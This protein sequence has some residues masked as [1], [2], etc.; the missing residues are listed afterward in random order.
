MEQADVCVAAHRVG[1]RKSCLHEKVRT[2]AKHFN[3][4]PFELAAHRLFPPMKQIE[5]LFP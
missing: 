1:P 4:L 2:D 3:L 5:K